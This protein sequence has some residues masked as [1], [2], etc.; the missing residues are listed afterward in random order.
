MLYSLKFDRTPLD[1]AIGNGRADLVQILQL[2][3]VLCLSSKHT[4]VR[5]PLNYC[6]QLK[7]HVYLFT[8]WASF[9]SLSWVIFSYGVFANLIVC[10]ILCNF[11]KIKSYHGKLFML[12]AHTYRQYG[13]W[14]DSHDRNHRGG[15]R[16]YRGNCD[17]VFRPGRQTGWDGGGVGGPGG[18]GGD[19]WY[20][21]IGGRM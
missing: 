16:K 12:T 17:R 15:S 21:W 13:R 8:I 18:R 6:L 2:A 14:W 7:I 3:Q 5:S 11:K 9:F 10:W 20:E 19:A 1:I 4:M